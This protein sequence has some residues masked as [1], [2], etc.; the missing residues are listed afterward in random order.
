MKLILVGG[1]GHAKVAADAARSAGFEILGAVTPSPE[2]VTAELVWLGDDSWLSRQPRDANIG[3]HLA[4][5]PSPS[6]SILF[7]H[8][9][10]EGWLM[11]TIVSASAEISPSATIGA[12]VLIAPRA[13]LNAACVI[14]SNSIINTAAVVEHDVR[15]GSHCHIGPAAV[16]CGGV[17]LADRVQVGAGAI[18]LPGIGLAEGVVVGAG[19]IVTRPVHETG[20]TVRNSP[21]RITS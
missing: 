14:A 5:G 8:L 13:V 4:F 21:A 20:V 17:N 7:D 16:L 19:A 3:C 9:L 11:P 1:G 10:A 12:G 6:R 15:I 18:L 2:A